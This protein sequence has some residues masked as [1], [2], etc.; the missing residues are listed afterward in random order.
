MQAGPSFA[1]A[2]LT[3]QSISSDGGQSTQTTGAAPA[4][5]AGPP[6]RTA[7]R[8]EDNTLSEIIV[9]ARRVEE[10]LQDVP[11]SIAVFDQQQLTNR[12][13]VN[14]QDLAAYTPSLS[15]NNNFG[16]QNASFAIRGFVQDVNTQPSVGVYFAD[17]VAPRG[18]SNN[19]PIGDGAGPGSFFDLQNVQV[20]KGP[21]GTL[22]GRNTTGGAILIVP[23]KPTS[24]FEGYV[25]GSYGNYDMKRIQAVVNVPLTDSARFRLGID[26]QS[27][28]G[29][30]HN[31]AGTSPS[32]LGDVNY[33]AV[34]AS[35]VVDITPNIENYSILSY[36]LS[37][38]DGEIQKLITC[39]PALTQANFIG[40]LAC[41]QLAREQ[42]K[43]AGFYTVQNPLNAPDT[44]LQTWQLINT[45]TIHAS[46]A[47]TVKNIV[48][49]AQLAETLRTPLFGADLHVIIPGV[50]PA[51]GVPIDF[52]VST[53][54]PG[55]KTADESTA[56]EEIQLQGNAVDN[57]LIWQAGA[58]FEA[59]DPL[60]KVGSQSPVL[61]DCANSDT[62]DCIS[63]LGPGGSI[64]YTAARTRFRNAGLYSQGTYK[65]TDVLKLTGGLRYT[66]DRVNTDSQ[67]RTYQV[68]TPGVGVPFCTNPDLSLPECDVRYR[69]SS[70]A[71]T[72]LIDLD[73]TPTDDVLVYGKYTRGYRAGGIVAPAPTEF[74]TF[75]P[76]KVDTYETGVKTSFH[77]AV[78]GTFNVAAFYNDFSNQQLQ[79]NLN[80]KPGIPVGPAS[81]IVNAG[82]SRIYGLEVESSVAPFQ[83]FVIEG[84]YAY[85]N[86][87]IKQVRFAQPS[88]ASP[89]VV[90]STVRA[91]DP[92]ALSPK[93]KAALTATYTLPLDQSIG[94]ISFGATLTHTD[95][96]LVNYV[97]RSSTVP[98]VAALSYLPALNL[99]NL[100][101][102]WNSIAGS[103]ADVAFF[104]TNVT[105]RQYYTYIPG[106][107]N[108]IGFETAP[109][110]LPRMYGGRIRYSF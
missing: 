91:G 19:L 95:K 30:E 65:L 101:L 16:S 80:P 73:Y 107:Y 46:D 38:T 36:L 105:D 110:G 94:R 35:F 29:Y 59:V 103:R 17:V 54:I 57:R 7:A 10:R 81:A 56:T 96:M 52:A 55:G 2:T 9:T 25:E 45:T 4:T 67:L 70:H 21:Q 60:A 68:P 44:R 78:N 102:N 83:G 1:E 40:L 31:D 8:A 87:R 34:R 3:Q 41:A 85:L 63:P 50:I 43:G 51:P 11:I 69:E 32:R 14:S 66:W 27:R 58:Y 89:F 97:D 82:K 100:N 72:W 106:L 62:F 76:E 22:F 15:A 37:Q 98:A 53:P 84:S 74:A 99:L 23:Q 39:N 79:L 104:V 109:L 86:T 90:D 6:T 42:A 77:A 20:L 18:A 88:A 26:H 75:K 28:E 24:A 48:S 49:Y 108:A 5:P 61:L 12:N 13:I 93:N 33:T 92:L 71:P 64:N 47:L